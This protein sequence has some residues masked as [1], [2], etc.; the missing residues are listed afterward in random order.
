LTE[1]IPL[2]ADWKAKHYELAAV[3]R[4]TKDGK[5]KRAKEKREAKNGMPRLTPV[6]RAQDLG[7]ARKERLPNQGKAKKKKKKKLQR[8]LKKSRRISWRMIRK[9]ILVI[10]TQMILVLRGA[11]RGKDGAYK[12]DWTPTRI[13]TE[14]EDQSLDKTRRK[15]LVDRED[16]VGF[17]PGLPMVLSIRIDDFCDYRIIYM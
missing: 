17:R 10:P 2:F 1:P 16:L 7:R 5:R 13:M 12:E 14:A 8:S 6:R 15:I 4:V 9:M 11:A 3:L